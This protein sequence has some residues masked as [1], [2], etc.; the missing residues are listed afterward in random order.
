MWIPESAMIDLETPRQHW[1][2]LH[3][4]TNYK[5]FDVNVHQDIDAAQ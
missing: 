3:R 5:R 2:N 4:F 1:R